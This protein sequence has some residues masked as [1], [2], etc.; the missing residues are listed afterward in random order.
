MLPGQGVIILLSDGDA[1]TNAAGANPARRRSDGADDRPPV[2]PVDSATG[3]SRSATTFRRPVLG[4]QLRATTPFAR[5]CS[6]SPAIRRRFYC[7]H[8]P[9]SA[10]PTRSRRS[11]STRPAGQ[12]TLIVS[13]GRRRQDSQP[14][15]ELRLGGTVQ[16]P[17]TT[18]FP[19]LN[20]NITVSN[21]DDRE[22]SHWTVTFNNGLGNQATHSVARAQRTPAAATRTSHRRPAR[23]GDHDNS[24]IG[25]AAPAATASTAT[26]LNQIF[27]DIGNDLTGARIVPNP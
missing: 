27:K 24:R 6:R 23:H 2:S 22:R 9:T 21:H 4:R 18:A 19:A 16:T 25:G 8:P 12:F 7:L 11:R 20:G 1:N 10:P 26:N 5:P 17:L 15:V 13:G 14:S 3:C